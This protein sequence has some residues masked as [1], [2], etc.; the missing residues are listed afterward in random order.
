MLPMLLAALIAGYAAHG[1]DAAPLLPLWPHLAAVL[2]GSL[3]AWTALCLGMAAALQ[4]RRSGRALMRWELG[5]QGLL[6]AWF[7]WLCLDLGWAGAV[8]GAAVALVPYVLM[9]AVQWATLARPITRLTGERWTA[10]SHVLHQARFSAMPLIVGLI[11]ADDLLA[12]AGSRWFGSR[13]DGA[14][15]AR[16]VVLAS[17]TLALA[18]PLLVRLL[19]ARPMPPGPLRERLAEACAAMGNPGAK[20]M[21]W[22]VP[23]P[24]FYNAM[25]VGALPGLRYVVFTDD[26]LRDLQDRELL[27]V[28]GHEIGHNQHRHLWLYLF[29]LGTIATLANAL[30]LLGARGLVEPPAWAEAMPQVWRDGFLLL[31]GA[32]FV[33]RVLFGALSRACERQADLAGVRLTGDPEA[34]ESALKTVAR[35][36]G[37][38]ETAPNWRHRSIAQRVAYLR[39]V[40]AEPLLATAHHHRMR[41][42]LVLLIAIMVA[43]LAINWYLDPARKAATPADAQ[44]EL[45]QWETADDTLHQAL[46]NADKGDPTALSR[47]YQR[48]SVLEK[49]RMLQLHF[50]LVTPAEGEPEGSKDPLIYQYRRRFT[51]FSGI[52]TENPVLNLEL[53]NV[54]AYG[55]VAGTTAPTAQDLDQARQL[56]PG[57]ELGVA[58]LPDS[59][60]HDTIGCVHFALGDFTK[61]RDSFTRARTALAADKKITGALRSHL[62]QLYGRRLAAAEHNLAAANGGTLER[63]P[64]DWTPQDQ[65][66]PTAPAPTAAPVPAAAPEAPVTP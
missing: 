34:M 26:L 27:A 44:T 23:L 45:K 50:A 28:L 53:D 66:H 18:P 19:G 3:A 60:I 21:R 24:R 12:A 47:W 63:L 39:R 17:I 6:L 9:A 5:G 62:E 46:I 49:R 65:P 59:A 30:Q 56:L 4:R 52:D 36:S 20:L 22:S 7:A 37:Q 38:A 16:T 25:V 43:S 40:R 51:A 13:S 8:P 61:A 10:L 1:R 33:Y 54:L 64:L 42:S 11:L 32:F 29:F 35:L 55:L 31:V 57:L 15:L 48:A 2:A 58:K 41:Y 14:D